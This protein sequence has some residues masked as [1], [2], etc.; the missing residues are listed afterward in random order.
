[1]EQLSDGQ[2]LFIPLKDGKP[3]TPEEVEQLP[4]EELAE[5]E[6]HQDEL[7]QMA[8]RVIQQQ[9][10]IQRQLSTDV[11]GVARS[12]AQQLIA[13]LIEQLQTRYDN[14]RLSHWLEQLGDHVLDHLN[15]FRESAGRWG[16]NPLATWA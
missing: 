12:F 10:E 14:E 3:M 5:L 11:R 15:R 13:P 8:G 1:M 4:P 7:V 2:I 16:V 9:L 6:S